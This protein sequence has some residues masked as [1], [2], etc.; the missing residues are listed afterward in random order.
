[1]YFGFAL[2]LSDMDLWNI[3]LLDRHVDLLGTDIPSKHFVCI[4]NIFKTSSRHVFK[5]SSRHVFK[6]SWKLLQRNNFS[7]FKTSSRHLARGLEDVFGRRLQ[8]LSEDVKLLRLR[9]A[10][11]M[12]WRRLQDV[13]KTNK[14][15]LGCNFYFFHLQTTFSKMSSDLWA[16]RFC[17]IVINAIDN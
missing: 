13:F 17:K 6:T 2:K 1:M 5:T 16:L 14:Y 9:H 12:S 8:D 11:D 4:H 3:D 10:E 15:L 7:S